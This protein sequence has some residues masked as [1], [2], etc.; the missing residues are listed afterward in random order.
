MSQRRVPPDVVARSPARPRACIADIPSPEK[1]SRPQKR[2]RRMQQLAASLAL[3]QRASTPSAPDGICFEDSVVKTLHVVCS[4]LGSIEASLQQLQPCGTF[5]PGAWFSH[6]QTLRAD[7]PDYIPTSCFPNAQ[8]SGGDSAECIPNFGQPTRTY[9]DEPIQVSNVGDQLAD[10]APRV[11][12][13]DADALTCFELPTSMDVSDNDAGQVCDDVAMSAA[14]YDPETKE[15]EQD[16][17]PDPN[18][19][20][21]ADPKDYDE[22]SDNDPSED[23]DDM[24]EDA[25]DGVSLNNF[26]PLEDDSGKIDDEVEDM[27]EYSAPEEMTSDSEGAHRGFIALLPNRSLPDSVEDVGEDTFFPLYEDVATELWQTRKFRN[28]SSFSAQVWQTMCTAW[29]ALHLGKRR[30]AMGYAA[31]KS[32]LVTHVKETWQ[33]QPPT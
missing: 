22:T 27:D 30:R 32:C 25:G 9:E 19:Q 26:I 3:E 18:L 11:L 17:C 6:G 23:C 29:T 1:L 16:E 10:F 4:R 12:P 13:G 8:N 28:K 15:I 14:V 20:W 24:N 33:H 2:R 5:A 31:V 7:A 21:V